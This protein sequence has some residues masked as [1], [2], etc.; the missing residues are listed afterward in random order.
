MTKKEL[1]KKL[2]NV[3][4]DAEIYL[5]SDAEGN[6]H[7]PVG[8]IDSGF[9]LFMNELVNNQDKNEYKPYEWEIIQQAPAC[10][11]IYPL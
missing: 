1:L 3:P 7:N 4:D 10:T 11:M 8:S 2:E 9:H 6:D 5:A